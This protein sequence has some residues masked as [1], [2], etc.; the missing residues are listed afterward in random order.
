MR[1]FDFLTITIPIH[2]ETIL[3]S[4]QKAQAEK[5]GCTRY[6]K[7]N[8]GFTLP[9]YVKKAVEAAGYKAHLIGYTTRTSTTWGFTP[10]SK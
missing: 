6:M 9:H 5:F 4:G 3:T 7:T 1:E 8:F 2:S 10:A